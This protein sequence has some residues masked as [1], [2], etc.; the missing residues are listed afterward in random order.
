M[1]IGKIVISYESSASVKPRLRPATPQLKL[2]ADGSYRIAGGFKGLCGS[3]AVYLCGQGV[4]KNIVV[5]S[6]SGFKDTQSQ[7][8]VYDR[9][10]LTKQ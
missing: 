9:N 1:H 2:R 5:I 6:R 3:L 10:T 8:T 4:P 7:K